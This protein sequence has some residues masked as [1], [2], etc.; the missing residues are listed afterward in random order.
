MAEPPRK[1]V[2]TMMTKITYFNGLY[3]RESYYNAVGKIKFKDGCIEFNAG[4]RKHS[5]SVESII[6]IEPIEK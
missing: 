2:T 5:I 3:G 1:E 4:G 6:S